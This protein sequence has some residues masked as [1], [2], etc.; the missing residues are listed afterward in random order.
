MASSETS[1]RAGRWRKVEGGG[2]SWG[3]VGEGGQLGES[4]VCIQQ[5][6][7][8]KEWKAGCWSQVRRRRRLAVGSERLQSKCGWDRCRSWGCGRGHIT[9]GGGKPRGCRSD[10]S[11]SGRGVGGRLDEKE[12]GATVEAWNHNVADDHE[13]ASAGAVA[14]QGEVFM[15]EGGDAA[16]GVEEDIEWRSG[17]GCEAKAEGGR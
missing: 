2:G 3:L 12:K 15:V 14:D 8:V 6:D 17:S 10:N 9:D 13:I 1:P 11:G 5:W 4:G 7:G 16:A